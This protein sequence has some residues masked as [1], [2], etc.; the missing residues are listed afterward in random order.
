MEQYPWR[1]A[2]VEN[3]YTW[4]GAELDRNVEVPKIR[5]GDSVR[6]LIESADEQDFSEKIYVKIT[7]IVYYNKTSKECR[8]SDVVRIFC[9]NSNPV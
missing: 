1:V 5:V 4:C 7:D 6:I 3:V 9:K 2:D 8:F